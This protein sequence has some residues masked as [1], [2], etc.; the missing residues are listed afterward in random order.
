VNIKTIDDGIVY[1]D[2]KVFNQAV[3]LVVNDILSENTM[4]KSR[5]HKVSI[6]IKTIAKIAKAVVESVVVV[7]ALVLIAAISIAVYVY[8]S[9]R[10]CPNGSDVIC[11]RLRRRLRL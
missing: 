3:D 10:Y 1:R 5:R 7:A 2:H 11:P 4:S 9:A 8:F 6:N